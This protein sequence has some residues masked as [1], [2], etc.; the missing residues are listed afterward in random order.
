MTA[1]ITAHQVLVKARALINDPKHW[2]A[3]AFAKA[4]SG[5]MVSPRSSKAVCW[6]A[7]GA[8]QRAAWATISDAK[9]RARWTL[10]DV[11]RAEHG[12]SYVGVN[13]ELGHEAIIGV[14]DLAIERLGG[15]TP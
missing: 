13:D 10:D 15:D 2:T 9:E 14:F 8:I 4:G 1:R 5:L 7:D 11:A 12:A 3:D 6:C